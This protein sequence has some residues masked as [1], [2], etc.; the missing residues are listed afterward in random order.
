ML[1]F[2]FGTIRMARDEIQIL[3]SLQIVKLY[4][5][6][7]TTIIYTFSGLLVSFETL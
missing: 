1:L 5:P 7:K 3:I 6:C 4:S 2:S